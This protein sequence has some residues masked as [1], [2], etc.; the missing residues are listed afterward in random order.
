MNIPVSGEV[1]IDVIEEMLTDRR[2]LPPENSWLTAGVPALRKGEALIVPLVW[3]RDA[4]PAEQAAV[5]EKASALRSDVDGALEYR[6]IFLNGIDVETPRAIDSPTYAAEL[7]RTGAR[8]A[9]WA[10]PGDSPRMIVCVT[11]GAPLPAPVDA[12]AVHVIPLE[13]IHGEMPPTDLN[14]TWDEVTELAATKS[15][16]DDV[17]PPGPFHRT[18]YGRGAL[19]PSD[20]R[21]LIVQHHGLPPGATTAAEDGWLAENAPVLVRG[22]AKIIPLIW[23]GYPDR[24]WN[25]Y[26]DDDDMRAFVSRVRA[27]IIDAAGPARSVDLA[28][29]LDPIDSTGSYRQALRKS[30]VDRAEWWALADATAIALVWMRGFASVAVHVIPATWVDETLSTEP[31]ADIDLWWSWKQVIELDHLLEDWTDR[32]S[33]GRGSARS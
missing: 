7:L 22:E 32:P 2:G 3:A 24:G 12:V 17:D 15:Y 13:W 27:S 6:W 28:D 33:T 29:T 20:A 25:P 21:D 26:A 31:A 10:G 11:Y 23:L 1:V 4:E 5:R 14:W 9:Y 19:L 16:H 18:T 8:D 30:R